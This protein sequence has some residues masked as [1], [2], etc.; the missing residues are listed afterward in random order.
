MGVISCDNKKIILFTNSN[1]IMEY[2]LMKANPDYRY[3]G[4]REMEDHGY[5]NLM[6]QSL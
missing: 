6:I 4:L 1:Q 3:I 5:Y 2:D